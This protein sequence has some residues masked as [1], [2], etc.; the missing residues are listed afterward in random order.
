MTDPGSRT[1]N[2]RLR[3]S[4]RDLF[5]APP[6]AAARAWNPIL[7]HQCTGCLPAAD[8]QPRTTKNFPPPLITQHSSFIIGRPNRPACRLLARRKTGPEMRAISGD[9]AVPMGVSPA[10]WYAATPHLA[11]A[12]TCLCARFAPR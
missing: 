9:G 7:L 3:T 11:P 10:P 12:L 5:L 2:L 8:H 4:T 1:A 6:H